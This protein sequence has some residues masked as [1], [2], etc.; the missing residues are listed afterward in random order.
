[1]TSPGTVYLVGAGPGDPGLVTLRALELVRA[2]DA[3]VHDRLIP[4]GLLGE[5]RPDADLRYAGK[6]P[7]KPSME[8]ETINA[9]LVELARQGKNVVRLKGGDPFVFGRGGEEAQALAAADVPFE[10]VPAVTAGIAASAYA[11]IPVTHRDEASAVAFVTGHEDP[12]KPESAL[13]WD[14]LARF[15]GTLVFYMGIKQ[16]PEIAQ[17]L[18][19]AG[20]SA[21]E[22]AA[23]VERGTL[24]GQRSVT[25]TLS[26]IADRGARAG[27]KPPAITV[28]GPVARL[29]D[30]I[31]WLDRRPLHGRTIAVTR[32]RAQASGLAA[33]LARLGAEVIETPAI[34]IEPRPFDGE[35]AQAA[36]EI[37]SFALVCVTSPNGAGLLLDAVEAV[38]GD[39]RSF[40]GVEVAA[41][42]PGTAAELASR[43]IRPDVVAGVS[44]AEGLLDALAGYELDGER[45]LVARAAEARDALP[46]GLARR[47]AQVEVVALYDT[48]AEQLGEEQLGAVERADYV[49]FA[50]SSTVRFFLDALGDRGWPNG[51]RVIS[52]GPITSATAR[53][54][55][56]DVHAEAERHDID[57]LVAAVLAEAGR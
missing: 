56:L 41:I 23:V 13:D 20:R 36:R 5:A 42:G 6:E 51:A 8:Q 38:G 14:A 50:S 35:I 3:I 9:L 46:D 40:A 19:D 52:I 53:E 16:L 17:R 47:G 15:P 11:G 44:T 55:G 49:T 31:A 12:Q 10:V 2:A 54:L 33:R 7:G 29:A 39:A 48:V 34:R 25:G 32:A 26:D 43:G 57:G 27:V 24:P 1:V 18:I 45:V 30:E 22:P 4:G 28:V 37:G 21:D